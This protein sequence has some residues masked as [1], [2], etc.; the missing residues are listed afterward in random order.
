M[1]QLWSYQDHVSYLTHSNNLVRRWAFN[2][3]EERSPRRYTPEVAKLIGGSDEHL[4]C[5]APKYLAH[6]RAIEYAPAILERFLKDKGNVPSNC[7]IALGDM[8]YEPAVDVILDRL[9]HCESPNT[10]FGILYYLGKIRRDDCHQALR[11]ILA[12][13]SDYYLVGAAAEHLLDHRDPEDVPLVL[14]TYVEKGEPDL[15]GDV[16]LKGLMSSVGGKGIYNDLT[17]YGREDLLDVPKEVLSE[18]LKQHPMISPEPKIMD[19][20]VRLIEGSQYQHI[21]TSLMFDAQNIFRSRFP[22][23]HSTDHLCGIYEHDIV[24]LA[25]L[26]EFSKRSSYWKRALKNEN[27][28]RNLASAVLACYF[29]MR[30]RVGYLQAL[31]PEATLEDMISALKATGPEFPKALQDRL[32]EL[33]PIEELKGALSDKLLTWGD[34]WIVRLMGRIGHDAFVPDLIRVVH[35]TDGLSFI[36]SDAVKALNGINESAHE[37]LLSAIKN[38]ELTDALDIFP[39]LEHLSYPESFDIAVQLWNEGDMDSF[40]IYAICLERIG[41]VR[42]IEALQEV[43]FEGNA[44]YAGDSLEALSLLHN[45]DIPELPTIRREREAHLERQK[46]RRKEL[47]E[48]AGKANKRGIYDASSEKSNVTTFRR[49]TPKI[50]RN[51]PCPCGSGKKYKKCCMNKNHNAG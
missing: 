1:H 24:A 40:E 3:I 9:T 30:E 31:D 8:H 44:I 43:F 14:R 20:A 28:N 51:V 6:H 2:A 50:G 47:A 29:S 45:R 32:I 46:E 11:D 34:I 35:D 48:L 22:E 7:A 33:S 49:E 23:G 15:P 27:I 36:H 13:L 39:L 16:F 12:Q 38:G 41:D 10:L 21:A 18:M 42:G 17:E 25:F 37:S 5:S 4:A 19:E 26:E